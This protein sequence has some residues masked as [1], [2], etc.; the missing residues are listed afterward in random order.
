M[1][2]LLRVAAVAV[3]VV[4]GA[5]G[6]WWLQQGGVAAGGPATAEGD[7][8]TTDGALKTATVE[9]RTLTVTEDFDA[10]LGYTTDYDVL[11]GLSGTLTWAVPAG[12]VVTSGQLLYE[13]D[14][15]NRAALMY[16]S[17]PAWRTLKS[18]VANGADIR[19]LEENL[20]LLGYARK[21]D[22]IDRH[23]D[24]DTTAAVKRWQTAVGVAVDGEVELGEV[25]FLPESIRVTEVQ[26]KLGS[27]V[28]PGGTLMTV[29]SNR[30]V[31]SLDLD[32]TDVEL[33]DVGDAVSV[34]LPDEKTVDGTVAT[35][36]RVAESSQDQQGGTS[37]T[38][39]V[40]ISLDDP[41]A[42]G[43]LDHAPVTVTVVRDSREDVLTVPVNALLALIEGGYAVEV[44]DSSSA[45]S[46]S[47]SSSAVAAE[48]S[49]AAS[50]A[51]SGPTTRLVRV[52]PGLFDNGHVE[53]TADGLEAGDL[54]VVPS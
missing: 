14:G 18:G 5:A 54:V 25:V 44:V 51:P 52:E 3:V 38:L 47:P 7:G 43:D 19:Q 16:G 33:I 29:T 15:V 1:S 9:R 31:V 35:I 24:S 11:G 30:R 17:R 12:T 4:A 6:G 36:G 37:T 46:A 34:E 21:G 49:P 40:T 10:T 50:V 45:S 20:R 48:G 2:R 42:A 28:G 23:W 22:V 41:A 26:A 13:T 53:I 32:A 27:G 8:G 39:P